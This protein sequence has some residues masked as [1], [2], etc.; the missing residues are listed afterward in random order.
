MLTTAGGSADDAFR[1]V[2]TLQSRYAHITVVIHRMCKSA[3]TLIALTANEIVMSDAGELGPLDVQ[4]PR[5]EEIAG[6]YLSGLDL[7]HALNVLEQSLIKTYR[8]IVLDIRLGTGISTRLAS[9]FASKLTIQAYRP[10]YGQ[11][12]PVRLGEVHR[13]IVIASAYGHRIASPNVKEGAV[14]L[15]VTGYPSHSFVIDRA[16]AAN[17]FHNVRA[18]DVDELEILE[19]LPPELIEV[20]SQGGFIVPL[21]GG[22]DDDDADD[23]HDNHDNHEG[24]ADHAQTRS[25]HGQGSGSGDPD[26]EPA[27]FGFSKASAGGEKAT[28]DD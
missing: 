4:L 25:P 16:E 8:N 11:I 13:K 3:G 17:L 26:P 7:I 14:E 2:R 12:D 10:I 23:N 20:H 27:E 24:Q 28:S 5:E 21:I 9:K 19:A 22:H 1:I 18:P 6:P 15:L